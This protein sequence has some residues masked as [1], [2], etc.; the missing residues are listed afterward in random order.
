MPEI[1]ASPP[2]TTPPS[3]QA[4]LKRAWAEDG[5]RP[6]EMPA[7]T[8]P[9][10]LAGSTQSPQVLE[11]PP[12]QPVTQA[13]PRESME[14]A[15][16][17]GPACPLTVTCSGMSPSY[18]ACASCCAGIGCSLL[19]LSVGLW[20]CHCPVATAEGIAIGGGSAAG[21]SLLTFLAG[22]WGCLPQCTRTWG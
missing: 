1:I 2:G 21:A 19:A 20:A 9:A 16:A 6:V 3:R 5:Q 18:D 10:A 8:P 4:D 14:H 15:R 7:D 13:P 11:M 12:P 22:D 17:A